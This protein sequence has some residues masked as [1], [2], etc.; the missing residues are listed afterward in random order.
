MRAEPSRELP[1]VLDDWEPFPFRE[2]V[3]KIHSRC[4]LACDYCYVYAMADRSWR[5]QPRAMSSA[6]ARQTAF[7]IGEHTQRHG[8]DQITVVLHGGEPLLAGPD[9]ISGLVTGVREAVG[10]DVSVHGQVQTNGVRLDEAFLALFSRLDLEVG[11]SLDGDRAAQDRHRVFASGRGSH[12][13]VGAGLTLLSSSRYRHLFGGLLCVI[14]PRNDPL[15]TYQ[16][17]VEYG[18]P[19]VDFLLPHGTW[20]V[21][22]PG[23]TADPARTPYADWLIAIFDEWYRQPRTH[24]RL[25]AEIIRA[26]LGGKSGVESI[27][28]AP[29]TIVVVETNGA[30][31]QAD[32]VKAAFHGASHTGL[33]VLRDSFD[34]A[35]RQPQIAIRQKGIGGLCAKCQECR[36]SLVCGGGLYA[37]RYRSGMGFSNPSVYC[38]DLMRLIDHIRQTVEADITARLASK[39]KGAGA[40]DELRLPPVAQRRVR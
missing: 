39:R 13:E 22:P 17:L 36:L 27:G 4:D 9:F 1:T 19:K 12:A 5:D 14:D 34:E 23:R 10:S 40:L 6:I 31:E 37:H 32:T 33:H 28:A 20:D 21:P 26:L 15:A 2:F 18:P 30:I 38:P 3:L 29:T 7:R 11:V 25:F 24:V 35:L 16:A 8:L